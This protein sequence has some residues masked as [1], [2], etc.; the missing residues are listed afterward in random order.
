[1]KVS[2][3]RSKTS[4]D[5]MSFVYSHE[6]ATSIRVTVILCSVASFALL[7]YHSIELWKTMQRRK[8]EPIAPFSSKLLGISLYVCLISALFFNIV[9]S[10]QMFPTPNPST[11]PPCFI[12]YCIGLILYGVNKTSVYYSYLLRLDLSYKDTSFELNKCFL[13]VLYVLAMLYFCAH[14]ASIIIHTKDLHGIRFVW[15]NEYGFCELSHSHITSMTATIISIGNMSIEIIIS[16]VAL[17]LFIKPLCHLKQIQNDPALHNLIIK[18]ALLN[19]IMVISSLFAVLVFITT[20]AS[21]L[22]FYDNV[23]NCLCLVLMRKI[24]QDLFVKMCG[25]CV[26]CK[27]CEYDVTSME[28]E[29]NTQNVVSSV[30]NSP[31]NDEAI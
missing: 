29:N 7:C 17:V 2:V 12:L 15:N 19:S 1:M 10:F 14:P 30:P 23:I 6:Y 11:N 25:V 20:T 5:S 18:V 4:R 8:K 22:L 21:I 9:T 13:R 3:K 28:N 27:C 24:H 16:I 31:T 26:S